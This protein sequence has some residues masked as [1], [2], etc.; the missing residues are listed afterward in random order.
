ME[1][2]ENWN[3]LN[4]AILFVV[5]VVVLFQA[6][7]SVRDRWHNLKKRVMLSLLLRDIFHTIRRTLLSSA[8]SEVILHA[9]VLKGIDSFQCCRLSQDNEVGAC[10]VPMFSYEL[11]KHKHAIF[12]AH[13]IEKKI[14]IELFQAKRLEQKLRRKKSFHQNT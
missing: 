5:V 10:D 4:F 9:D 1:M 3:S 7:V 11:S 12:L 14:Q 13:V 8:F 2:L 6:Y